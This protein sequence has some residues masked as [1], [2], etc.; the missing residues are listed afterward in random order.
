MR[1]V[2]IVQARMGSTRLPG[3][4]LLPLAGAP[5]LERQLER[6]SRCE[7]VDRIVVATTHREADDDIVSLVAGLGGVQVYR[8]PEDDVLARYLGAAREH[9]A[10]VVVRVTS[11]CPL[12]DAEV[13]DT[14]I[15]LC[16]ANQG[17]VAYV[18]NAVKRTYPRGLD[19]EVMPMSVLEQAAAEATDAA[20]REHVTAY[21]WRRPERFARLDVVAEE[22]DSDL[23]WTVDTP[24]DYALAV[25]IYELLYPVKPAFG[26][27]D[28]LAL[29]DARPELR[30]INQHVAQ[31]QV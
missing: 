7:L 27:R 31:K 16:L 3:K 14:A 18:S 30:D 4:V 9:G 12:I 2:L 6:L 15:S 5:M 11:D 19:V 13:I 25:R 8:G 22:D 21:I 28:V 20:D 29:V 17:R 1:V 10:D 24:E 26:Y 23:R